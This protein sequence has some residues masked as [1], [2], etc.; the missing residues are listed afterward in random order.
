MILETKGVKQRLELVL[1]RVS[2]SLHAARGQDFLQRESQAMRVSSQ[3]SES[4]QRP[5]LSKLTCLCSCGRSRDQEMR[6]AP[7]ACEGSPKGLSNGLGLLVWAP[8]DGS[9]T[10]S[11]GGV[12]SV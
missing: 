12:D 9:S 1:A 4:I 2:E 7:P 6:L 11:P 8:P 10:T 3:I 5:W